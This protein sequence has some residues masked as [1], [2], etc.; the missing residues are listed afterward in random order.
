VNRLGHNENTGLQ[1][2]NQ[3]C[4]YDFDLDL[5]PYSYQED[6]TGYSG[7]STD[8]SGPQNT[9]FFCKEL[10]PTPDDDEERGG[11]LSPSH[12]LLSELV[13][14]AEEYT[15]S[16]DEEKSTSRDD[17]E[18]LEVGYKLASVVV[19]KGGATGGH[20]TCYRRLLHEESLRDIE[21]YEKFLKNV[22]IQRSDTSNPALSDRWVHISDNVV[23]PASE[24]DVIGAKAYLLFYE[25][26]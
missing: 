4:F 21:D 24:R 8:N 12:R 13:K 6:E 15:P 1:K 3:Q 17:N 11:S 5:L 20:Y 10:L 25:K 26:E 19:H 14:K 18:V 22:L 9:S 7:S 23:N 16:K 2:N